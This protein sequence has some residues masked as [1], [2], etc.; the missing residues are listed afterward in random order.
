MVLMAF[1][2]SGLLGLAALAARRR[3]PAPRPARLEAEGAP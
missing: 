1:C 3:R 2:P